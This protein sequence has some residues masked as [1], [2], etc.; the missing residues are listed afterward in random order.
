MEPDHDAMKSRAP[1]VPRAGAPGG[2]ALS[3]GAVA[4]LPLQRDE[5]RGDLLLLAEHLLLRGDELPA[6]EITAALIALQR[7]VGDGAAREG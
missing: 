6:Q 5:R 4:H 7:Q 1:C 3:R 2:S